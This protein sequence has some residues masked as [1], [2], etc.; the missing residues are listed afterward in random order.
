MIS[1]HGLGDLPV[2]LAAAVWTI[3]A[4]E[5]FAAAGRLRGA[6]MEEIA[7]Q[8][9]E[10]QCFWAVVLCVLVT[11]ALAGSLAIAGSRGGA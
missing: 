10:P 7:G 11:A 8:P 2:G 1:G 6:G 4:R 9:D 5:A 3:A